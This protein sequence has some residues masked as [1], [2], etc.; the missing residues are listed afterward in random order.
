MKN[1]KPRVCFSKAGRTMFKK[2]I[3]NILP[4]GF[5]IGVSALIPVQTFAAG[6]SEEEERYGLAG[7]SGKVLAGIVVHIQKVASTGSIKLLVDTVPTNPSGHPLCTKPTGHLVRVLAGH[8]FSKPRSSGSLVVTG[9]PE[10]ISDPKVSVGD[11]LSIR[12]L[13]ITRLGQVSRSVENRIRIVPSLERSTRSI[14]MI[15]ADVFRLWPEP[16]SQEAHQKSSYPHS[17][18]HRL[19]SPLPK[20]A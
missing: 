9:S 15:Q 10:K 14:R 12:G 20:K 6:I 5:F 8:R 4:A 3:K 19:L 2:I 11:C 18:S 13:S 17:S 1:Q 16:T 7:K